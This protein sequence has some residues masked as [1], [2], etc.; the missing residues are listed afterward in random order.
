MKSNLDKLFKT[1]DVLAEQGV[2]FA[3]ND[4]TS[5]KLAHMNQENPRVKKAFATHY[6]PYAR[7]MEMG[8][9]PPEKN[10]EIQRKL[11]VDISLISWTGVNDEE[12]GKPIECNKENALALF[13][14]LPALFDA[15]WKYS[16]DYQNYKEDL[17][18]S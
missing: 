18:N 17:G 14:R 16:N 12:T 1:N 15:L 8:T 5:F 2:D 10:L 7:Q 13:K 4:E 9:L 11:F 6:K 3:L